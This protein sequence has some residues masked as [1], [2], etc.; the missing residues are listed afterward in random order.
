MVRFSMKIFNKIFLIIL[1]LSS[2]TS[3]QSIDEKKSG[4]VI[5]IK[6]ALIDN[7][8]LYVLSDSNDYHFKGPGVIALKK[9]LISQYNQK[10][11]YFSATLEITNNVV[12]GSY[13]IYLDP[14]EL[15]KVEQEDLTDNY[16][17]Y[18]NYYVKKSN[19]YISLA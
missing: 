12:E 9:F 14:K 17:F 19:V 16:H 6:S 5:E 10:V 15:N 8:N 3:Y 2:C 7:D 4:N 18:S 11:V 13:V 1:F